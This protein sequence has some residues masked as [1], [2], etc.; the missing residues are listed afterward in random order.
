VLKRNTSL[1]ERLNPSAALPA[2]NPGI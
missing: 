1:K 2:D